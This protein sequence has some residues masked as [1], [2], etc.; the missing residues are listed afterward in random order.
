[1]ERPGNV[2]AF[3]TTLWVD[4]QVGQ[5]GGSFQSLILLVFFCF[6]GAQRPF[7]KKTHYPGFEMYRNR[8]FFS[9]IQL[10]HHI[11]YPVNTIAQGL[12]GAVGKKN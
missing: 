2:I 1:M 4:E 9:E 8:I 3:S 11:L 10:P 7:L 5:P 12:I 6:P